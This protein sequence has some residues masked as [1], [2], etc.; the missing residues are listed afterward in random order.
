MWRVETSSP[1]HSSGVLLQ[2]TLR[3]LFF[4]QA[5]SAA[6]RG[7]ARVARIEPRAARNERNAS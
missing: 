6:S 1:A 4:S 5:A 3:I 2:E 7:R